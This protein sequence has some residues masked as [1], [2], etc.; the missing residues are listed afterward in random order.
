[1]QIK[2][3]SYL[4]A[5]AETG[6][7]SGAGKR[8]GISQ[9]TLSV[10]LSDLEQE[11]GID[12]FIRN[13]KKLLPTPAGRIYLEAARKILA[14]QEQTLR[15]IRQLTT[16]APVEIRLGASPLRGSDIIGKIFSPFSARYPYVRLTLQDGYM[17]DFHSRLLDGSISFSLGTCFDTESADFDYITLFQEEILVTVPGF[18]PLALRYQKHKAV[19]ESQDKFPS[20]TPEELSDSPF[21]LMTPGSTIRSISD[22]I[23]AQAGFSPTIVFES[24]NTRMIR[25]M[26]RGGSGIGFLPRSSV[27]DQDPNLAYLSLSPRYFLDLCVILKKGTILSEEE[28]YL[29]YLLILNDKEIPYY[30]T[31]FNEA[32]RSIWN[33]FHESEREVAQS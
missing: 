9:P 19:S 5:L 20:V 26:I 24:V 31:D 3:M 7:L 6:T 14:T 11:L 22:Y 12:L 2:T 8:L 1:M 27:L 18:H 23:I 21:I 33:E 10:F 25:N 28:R 16:N 29:I 4:I 17:R 15:S 32:A 13:K 30:H